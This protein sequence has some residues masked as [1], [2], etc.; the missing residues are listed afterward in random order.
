MSAVAA[1]VIDRERPQGAS[2]PRTDCKEVRR[3]LVQL[4]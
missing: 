4:L 1:S 2:G 3:L